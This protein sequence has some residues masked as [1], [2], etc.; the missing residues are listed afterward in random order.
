[1]YRFCCLTF[2]MRYFL[3]INIFSLKKFGFFQTEILPLTQN[4]TG[5]APL[6]TNNLNT[7][8]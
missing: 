1:M 7:Y 6:T 3:R 5:S 2:K 4:D 8:K